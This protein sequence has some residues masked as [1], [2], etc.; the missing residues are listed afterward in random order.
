MITGMSRPGR[1]DPGHD[2]A[3]GS[4]EAGV[5]RDPSGITKDALDHDR[6]G[7][8]DSVTTGGSPRR[9]GPGSGLGAASA[10]AA[11]SR[12]DDFSK[13]H[14][15]QQVP[16]QAD[17]T[18]EWSKGWRSI[19]L[20]AVT[21]L[22]IVVGLLFRSASQSGQ[23][24]SSLEGTQQILGA[25]T[26]DPNATMHLNVEVFGRRK[27]LFIHFL[28]SRSISASADLGSSRPRG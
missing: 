12:A 19:F 25:Y 27:T 16:D 10:H 28:L 20:L 24:P 13:S 8:P 15:P 6:D 3:H 23:E 18:N 11:D 9:E 26:T 22:F 1:G 14:E 7:A 5:A 17:G 21:I 4:S 2:E